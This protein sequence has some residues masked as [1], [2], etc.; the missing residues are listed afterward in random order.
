MQADGE[1]S[2]AR[3]L[4][5]RL[6]S[7]SVR[8]VWRSMNQDSV[9]NKGFGSINGS[10]TGK[11]MGE[12]VN[13]MTRETL[14]FNFDMG[15]DNVAGSV[16]HRLYLSGSGLLTPGAGN[17]P[18]SVYGPDAILIGF[19]PIF[20]FY[21]ANSYVQISNISMRDGG[22]LLF[23]GGDVNRVTDGFEVSG[24]D[25]YNTGT[26]FYISSRD[27]DKATTRIAIDIHD[28][29]SNFTSGQVFGTYSIGVTGFFRNNL[30][31]NGNLCTSHGGATYIQNV[32]S[33]LNGVPEPLIIEQNIADTWK[34]AAGSSA[35]DGCCYY[36]DVG[37]V[38]SVHRHNVAL[39]SYVAFQCGAGALSYWE[40]N[41]SINCEKFG[42]WNNNPSLVEASDYRIEHNLHIGALEGTF[43]HGEDTVATPSA[44][45]ITHTGTAENLVGMQVRNN[46][47]IVAEGDARSAMNL[48]T[49]D[50]W[51]SGKAQCEN[52]VFICDGAIKIASNA[53][54]VD[55]TGVSSS[56]TATREQCL[57]SSSDGMH[58]RISP[59][60]ALWNA[61]V[62][63]PRI[64]I[65][66][67]GVRYYSPP[68]IGPHEP[69][70]PASYHSFLGIL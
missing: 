14:R 70:R 13:G 42:M 49:T 51:N 26:P 18:S 65:D 22:G 15:G 69:V 10:Q 7:A 37:D 11:H 32:T 55:K 68:S 44:S 34:N 8:G 16:N 2:S 19:K 48:L 20:F 35:F 50:L 4:S 53:G 54:L 25:T 61:G 46:V 64:N 24:I 63:L 33:T 59:S 45:T 23:V 17:D 6:S 43:W 9:G 47:I 58:Y 5:R 31:M 3:K 1:Y 62:D 30:M 36:V 21:N 40:G 29:V 60:S 66:A 27:G 56:I 67:Y 52:N 41:T 28:N 38:G 12:Y 57:L 39:N